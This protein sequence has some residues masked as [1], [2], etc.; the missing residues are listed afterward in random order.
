MRQAACKRIAFV[1][2]EGG[3][4]DAG[5]FGGF[6]YEGAGRGLEFVAVEGEFDYV[7]H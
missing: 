6:D 4:L 5:G 1:I 3:D 7:S 2:A